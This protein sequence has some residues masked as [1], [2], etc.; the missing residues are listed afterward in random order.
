MIW[1]LALVLLCE[2]SAE[3]AY[4]PEGQNTCSSRALFDFR[5]CWHY[6]YE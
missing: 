3:V 2:R 4:L 1:Q 6:L 5:M